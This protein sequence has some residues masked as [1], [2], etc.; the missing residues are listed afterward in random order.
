MNLDRNNHV[1]IV[2]LSDQK[3]HTFTKEHREAMVGGS[4]SNTQLYPGPLQEPPA[5]LHEP[6]EE[7]RHKSRK[8]PKLRTQRKGPSLGCPKGVTAPESRCDTQ[9]LWVIRNSSPDHF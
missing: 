9:P 2:R 6:R 3:Q 7:Q 8:E 1:I 5:H 4:L